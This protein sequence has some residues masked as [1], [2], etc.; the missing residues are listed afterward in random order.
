MS[1]TCTFILTSYSQRRFKKLVEDAGFALV[2]GA[3]VSPDETA[4]TPDPKAPKSPKTPKKAKNAKRS[5]ETAD[6]APP[7]KLKLN[8]SE[9]DEAG[10]NEA[11]TEDDP[12]AAEEDI[13]EA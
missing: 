10:E 8:P 3:V 13:D 9:S 6:T 2:N 5:M 4:T 12:V 1:F 11:V 7:K